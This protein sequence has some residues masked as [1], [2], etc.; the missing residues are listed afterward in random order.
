MNAI[1]S[2]PDGTEIQCEI[3][4]NT[5]LAETMPDIPEDLSIV[6]V[7]T[8]ED[9][10]VYHDAILI[11]CAMVNGKQG[12]GFIEEDPTTKKIRFL[13]EQNN[14]LTD[15]ILEMSTMLFN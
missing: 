9:T 1:I 2:F 6:T 8:D 3:N 12:F 13:Q 5:L 14:I 15:C 10:Y 7:T 4:G 11:R